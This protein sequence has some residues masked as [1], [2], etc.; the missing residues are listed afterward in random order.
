MQDKYIFPCIISY[1]NED[2][3]FYVNFPNLEEC[4]TD[5]KD[6]KEAISNAK[7]VLGLV[8][9]ERE[10]L[11]IEIPDPTTTFIKTKDNESI[12]YIEVWMPLV[13]ERVESKSVKKTL[14]IPKWL[15]DLA[16]EEE[17][18]YSQILQAALKEYLNI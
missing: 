13:R 9:Y 7:D 3:T 16:E 10:K 14:T 8:L 18:N 6:F 15:N 17:V 11:G 5:G 2:D 4:F 1:S 12:S